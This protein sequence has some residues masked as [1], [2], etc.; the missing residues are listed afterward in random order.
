M[1]G[2]LSVGAP[3]GLGGFAPSAV[4]QPAACVAHSQATTVFVKGTIIYA[5]TGARVTMIDTS[6]PRNPETYVAGSGATSFSGDGGPAK[7]AGIQVVWDLNMDAF[8][9]LYLV[10]NTRTRKITPGPDGM[11]N[12]GPGE[13]ITTVVGTGAN[14]FGGD[15]GPAT[16]AQTRN[17]RAAAFDSSGNMYIADTFNNRIR[18]VVPGAD[19]VFTGA[20]DE[21][22]TTVA[23]S[24]TAGTGGDGPAHLSDLNLPFHV[25]VVPSAQ[26]DTLH[27]V[28]GGRLRKITPGADGQINRSA[29]DLISTVATGLGSVTGLSRDAGGNFY[30][31]S[32][33]GD[34]SA[35]RRVDPAG[36]VTL[37]AG[38]LGLSNSGYSGD[39]GP[40]TSAKLNTPQDIAV[41][42]SNN[43]LVADFGNNR[44]RKIAAGADGVVAGA[45]DEIITT[46]AGNGTSTSTC[47]RLAFD[48]DG[49]LDADIAVYRPSDGMWYVKGGAVAQWGAEGDISVPG[50]YDGNG[51]TDLAVFR[52]ADGLWFIN[53]GGVNPGRAAQWGAPGDVPVPGDYD[54][55]GTTDLAVFRPSESTWYVNGG[56]TSQV[57]FAQWGAAG[58]IPVPGDYDG[59][60]T[61]DI[62]VF[63]PSTATWYVSGGTINQWGAPDDIPAPGDYDGNGTTDL[64][65][66]RPSTGLWY[67]LGGAT[68]QWGVSGDIPVP[69]DYDGD[70]RTEV[71]VFRPSGGLWFVLGGASEQWGVAGDVPLSSPY[72]VRRA[73]FQ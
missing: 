10:G 62:A 64:A 34:N 70:G 17:A 14:A 23:G 16:S 54:G 41:D 59:N 11:V 35:V 20:A 6:N 26:G 46:F 2:A 58:D 4:A 49:D 67:V 72:A 8:G 12:G 44:Y 27:L 30:V 21:I 53:E 52:P 50:D 61:T 51:T 38:I 33:A 19:G 9:N 57:I 63:R 3:L 39:G 48:Y 31:G 7:S 43:V 15:D 28:E 32:N 5:W 71:A 66:Y 36:V 69:G 18:K 73:L 40:A 13:V 25:I 60:R 45:A 42:A 22:I 56:G 55:N 37:V 65:V 47:S 24:G 29:D 1:L 68:H